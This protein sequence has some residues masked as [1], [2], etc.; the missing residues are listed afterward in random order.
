M[1]IN[2]KGLQIAK[3]SEGLSLKAYVCPADVVTIGWGTTKYPNG[4]AIQIGDQITVEMADEYLARDCKHAEEVVTKKVK[5][6]LNEN[7]FSALVSLVYNIGSGNF[8]KSTLLKSLNA[9]DYSEASEQFLV[10]RKGG[11]KV[12]KGLEIRRAKEKELFD[13]EVTA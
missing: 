2:N 6:D 3:D 11:G 7:Q 9:G 8:S 5:V 12:L 10:W 13:T 4:S 1:K